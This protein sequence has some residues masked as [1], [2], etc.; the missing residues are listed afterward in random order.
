MM[1]LFY[2]GTNIKKLIPWIHAGA[3]LHLRIYQLPIISFI[4]LSAILYRKDQ[5]RPILLLRQLLIRLFSKHQATLIRI[6]M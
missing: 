2:N 4:L 5:M 3:R 1:V 6:M